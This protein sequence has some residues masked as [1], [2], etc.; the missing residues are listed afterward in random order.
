MFST[1]MKV[2]Y[3]VMYSFNGGMAVDK[4]ENMY[5]EMHKDALQHGTRESFLRT[6]I[7]E[8][9]HV[10]FGYGEKPVLED[11]SFTLKQNRSYALVGASGSGKSTIAKLI[12]GFYKVD[13][14][15]IKIGGHPLGEYSEKALS[16]K[17]RVCISGCKAV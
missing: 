11:V 2:M 15:A 12:S 7:F 6:M 17:Y 5:E 13:K 10:T 8:F 1:I 9:D 3:V 14:G 16:G 4:L